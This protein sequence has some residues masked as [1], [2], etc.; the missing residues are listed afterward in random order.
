MFTKVY[1][2]L[3]FWARWIQSTHNHNTM[4]LRS[5]LMSNSHLHPH[6]ASDI[7]FSRFPIKI[8]YI[9]LNSTHGPQT[10]STFIYPNM[11][12]RVQITKLNMQFFHPLVTSSLL[13]TNI[14][15][16]SF[17]FNAKLAHTTQNG[18]NYTINLYRANNKISIYHL[19]SLITIF[20]TFLVTEFYIHICSL[21]D[22]S[23]R[24][25]N[26]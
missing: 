3:L 23:D 21:I 7:V 12:C 20:S 17:S 10:S 5:I 8:L 24:P 11:W 1:H 18:R 14:L 2:W 6:L 15:P 26:T 9:F 16:S 13:G 19:A 4:F 22:M 25:R